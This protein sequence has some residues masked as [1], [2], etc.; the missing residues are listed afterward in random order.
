MMTFSS[1][2]IY[3][4]RGSYVLFRWVIHLRLFSCLFIWYNF[5]KIFFCPVSGPER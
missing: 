3:L 5:R 2:L 4:S 1:N